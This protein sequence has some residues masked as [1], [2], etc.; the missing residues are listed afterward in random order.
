MSQAQAKTGK[1]AEKKAE[2]KKADAPKTTAT[3]D[4]AATTA[5]PKRSKADN[6]LRE[7]RIEKLVLNISVGET[8][9]KL[10]KAAKVLEDLTQQKPILSKA[11]FTI[12]TFGI[13]RFEKMATSVSI[14]GDIAEQ[15]LE[16]GLRVKEFELRKRNFSNSG[17]FGFGIQEH[18]DLGMRYDPYTGIFGM[19]FYVVLGRAGRRVAI[20]KRRAGRV[21]KNQKVTKAEA[22][23]WFK[24]KYEGLVL[25]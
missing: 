8:G 3:K 9:D 22:T 5:A 16:K 1:P 11:R 4:T 18:I 13:K 2:P 6:P 24:Q 19:D 15:I 10:T 17:N 21:G 25:N 7:I 23:N 14:R 20:K 12:R